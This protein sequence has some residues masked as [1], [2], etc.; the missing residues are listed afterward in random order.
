ML[1]VNNLTKN[2]GTLQAVKGINL[3]IAAGSFVAFL[4][5]NGSG[6][7]TTISM[8]TKLA[9]PTGGQILLDGQPVNTSDYYQQI[10]VVFQN[11]ILDDELTVW[12]NLTLR[13]KMSGRVSKARIQELSELFQL[14][15][16]EKQKYGTLSGGQKRRVD[17][18]RA[19]LHQPRI[20]FLDEPTTGLDIQSRKMIWQ[21][22]EKLQRETQL[23]IFLT[24]H[25][26]EEANNADYVYIL[27]EGQII[28]E[29]TA[30]KLRQVYT[31]NVLEI[32]TV[33][34]ERI[35]EKIP[36][37]VSFEQEG[38][39]LT[40]SNI[41][42]Q[43]AIEILTMNRDQISNFHFHEGSMDDVFLAVTKEETND[44][45]IN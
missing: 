26:L 33:V 31:T 27:K 35:S 38:Q 25:Y 15:T 44:E 23:T 4:G 2:Y 43:T 29:G 16:F 13:G 37:E 24:T 3:E 45:R 10:G 17:I 21:L 28:A 41:H 6:K 30:E 5:P 1:T 11:S 7:S 34:P 39:L 14:T 42:V 40:F 9:P 36:S 32:E 12:E 8:L 19:L 18:A 22:L 20:L